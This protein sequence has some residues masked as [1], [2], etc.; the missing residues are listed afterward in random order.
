[1]NSLLL[2]VPILNYLLP[3]IQRDQI[4]IDI[5]LIFLIELEKIRIKTHKKKLVINKPITYSFL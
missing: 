3:E 5:V 4:Q 2:K 1:M